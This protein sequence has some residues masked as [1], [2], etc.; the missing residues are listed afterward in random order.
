MNWQQ[1]CDDKTLHDLPYKI[2]L[3]QQGQVIMSPASVRHVFFQAE[4]MS[5]L[6]DNR[7]SAHQLPISRISHFILR[8]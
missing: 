4:I 2:E 6:R 1:V 3:N 5:L 7:H 8:P